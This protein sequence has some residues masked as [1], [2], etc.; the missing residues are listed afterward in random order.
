MIKKADELVVNIKPWIFSEKVKSEWARVNTKIRNN[1]IIL[2]NDTLKEI[3][4]VCT[5]GNFIDIF[6]SCL[7]FWIKYTVKYEVKTPATVL[8]KMDKIKFDIVYSY[9]I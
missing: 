6:L 8:D 1:T 3:F 2:S 5:R 4:F 7:F 9:N